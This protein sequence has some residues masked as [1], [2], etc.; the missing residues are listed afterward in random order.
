[1]APSTWLPGEQ[2]MT[3][4]GEV[5]KHIGAISGGK[6]SV[7][8]AIMLIEQCPE[9]S[10]QWGMHIDRKRAAGMVRPYAEIARSYWAYRPDHAPWWSC[11]ARQ[12]MEY[13]SIVQHISK[14]RHG[15]LLLVTPLDHQGEIHSQPRFVICAPN[16]KPDG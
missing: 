10:F 1:M 7:A 9:I 15:K 12:T 13:A 2:T 14:A 11:R 5:V 3:E 6:D 16:S 8:M 4:R